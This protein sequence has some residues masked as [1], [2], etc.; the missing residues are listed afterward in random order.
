MAKGAERIAKLVAAASRRMDRRGKSNIGR[1]MPPRSI[2]TKEEHNKPEWLVVR[3]LDQLPSP[4]KGDPG[5]YVV[6]I[7]PCH[8]N[9][10]VTI[11]R[12]NK[13]SAERALKALIKASA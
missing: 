3:H 7:C 6:R 4:Y 1:T 5:W 13:Q 11:R 2:M 12:P 10:P 9:E 8:W